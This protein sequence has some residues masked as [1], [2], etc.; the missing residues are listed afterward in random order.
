MDAF[1]NQKILFHGDRLKEYIDTKRTNAPVTITIDLTNKCNNRCPHCISYLKDKDELDYDILKHLLYDCSIIGVRGIVIT[2]GGE[3]LLYKKL[4]DALKY[5]YNLGLKFGLIT[6]GQDIGRS[7]NEWLQILKYLTWIRFSLDA[8]SSE[9]Y[10]YTHG[11]GKDKF[12]GVI[13]LINR[14]TNI[15]YINKLSTTIG[16]GY[17]V[18]I[19]TTLMEQED[20]H[21]AIK[22]T[23]NKG[24]DYFQ[25]R[26]LLM[27][28]KNND[29]RVVDYLQKTKD[30]VEKSGIDIELYNTSLQRR[31]D[32]EYDYCHG[33]HF[34]TSICAN[35]KIYYCCILKN[36]KHGEIGNLH[37]NSFSEIWKSNVVREIGKSINVSKCPNRC[38]NNIINNIINKLLKSSENKH[39]A[40]L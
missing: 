24:L 36:M 31:V 15:K 27:R 6:S 28:E 1:S 32:R 5:G 35:G 10:K 9:R 22:L 13:K 11:L 17:I 38:K 14:V 7:D 3:P 39:N 30:Y 19:D 18:N 8:G 37:K 25:L 40:F 33:G 23:I 16:I 20:I 4:I 26:P 21:K 29:I 34:I 2:G 12:D